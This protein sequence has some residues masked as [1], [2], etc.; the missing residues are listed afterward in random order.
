MASPVRGL[1]R[2]KTLPVAPTLLTAGNLASGVTAIL[3]AAHNQLEWGAYFLFIAMVCDMFDGKVARMTKTDGPFGAE[4]D[5]LADVISFGVAPAILVH[6]LVMG[7]S[8]VFDHGMRILWFLTVFYPVMAAIRLARYNV[9]HSLPGNEGATPHFRGIPSP[10]AAAVIAG[11]I[12]LHQNSGPD[13]GSPLRQQGYTGLESMDAFRWLILAALTTCALVM[14]STIRFPHIGNSFFGRMGF[15]K[16]IGLL[17]LVAALVWKPAH[18]LVLMTLGYLLFGLT[19]AA[20]RAMG[21]AIKG[22]DPTEDEEDEASVDIGDDR[23]L[24]GRADGPAP[25]R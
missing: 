21:R 22:K 14:V 13:F 10:G 17:L 12:I 1:K 3:C 23:T 9:E 8:G 20:I 11:L 18:V 25:G 7:E 24:P 5:S 4:L 15:G 6:R 19:G 2:L 16:L